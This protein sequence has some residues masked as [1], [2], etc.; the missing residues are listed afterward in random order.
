MF[1]NALFNQN[2][3]KVTFKHRSPCIYVTA[4]D[5]LP[6]TLVLDEFRTEEAEKSHN[7]N[8]R[9]KSANMFNNAIFHSKPQIHEMY[10]W[11]PSK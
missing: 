3:K 11:F 2:D 8:F 6:E 4:S 5:S 1:K 7:V 9:L 10:H